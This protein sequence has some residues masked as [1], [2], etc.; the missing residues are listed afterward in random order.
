M[1]ATRY[2]SKCV[3]SYSGVLHGSLIFRSGL[4]RVFII[5]IRAFAQDTINIDVAPRL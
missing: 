4:W 5:F 3:K 2:I 1:A